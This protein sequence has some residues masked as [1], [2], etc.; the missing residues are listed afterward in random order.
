MVFED[1]PELPFLDTSD[2]TRFLQYVN[3]AQSDNNKKHFHKACQVVCCGKEWNADVAKM[4]S[5][6]QENM[7]GTL[8]IFGSTLQA[9]QH[10]SITWRAV[11]AFNQEAKMQELIYVCKQMQ[12]E[13]RKVVIFCSSVPMAER[14]SRLLSSRGEI[15]NILV[16][17]NNVRGGE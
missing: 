5:L 4:E 11:H 2:V 7:R 3:L 16:T 17:N 15:S 10:A 13:R 8:K 14:V 1:L 6:L 9:L 12:L